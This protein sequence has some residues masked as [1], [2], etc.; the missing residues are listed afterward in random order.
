[1]IRLV[2]IISAEIGTQGK[3]VIKFLGMGT[4]DVQT[5]QQTSPYGFDSNPVAGLV[6]VYAK[7]G[8]MGKTVLLGY[9]NRD[10]IAGIGETRLYSTD[11]D[12]ELK[13]YIHLKND[14]T[15]EIGGNSDNMVRYSKL[16][17]AFNQLRDDFNSHTHIT[18]ATVGASPTPGTIA[19]PTT[20]SAADI[21]GA[22]IDKIK[23][24]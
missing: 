9:F 19:P 15:I 14:E 8:Q 12:G 22:K 18:T 10:Q 4:D 24:L 20:S 17:E 23:T 21:S 7:T 3:R 11:E 1:M 16:E 6:G 2:K 5:A 13:T